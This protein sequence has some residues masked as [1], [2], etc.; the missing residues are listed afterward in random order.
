MAIEA[1]R[2]FRDV[3]PKSKGGHLVQISS[4]VGRVASGGQTFYSAR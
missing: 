4:M 3:N 2:V 1:V